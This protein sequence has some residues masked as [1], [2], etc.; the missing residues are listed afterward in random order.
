ML[1]R[2]Y[3]FALEI[4]DRAMAKFGADIYDRMARTSIHAAPVAWPVAKKLLRKTVGFFVPK[5]H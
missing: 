3:G 4:A 2:Q 1:Y 5:K